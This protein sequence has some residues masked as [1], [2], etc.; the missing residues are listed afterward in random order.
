MPVMTEHRL[1]ADLP[2]EAVDAFLAVAGPQSGSTLMMAEIRHLG[3][4]LREI[5]P[6]HG[7]LAT[8]DAAY[9]FFGGG[10]AAT[11]EMVAGLQAALPV[12]KA[13]MA[14]WDAGRGYLNFEET[15]GSHTFYDEVTHRHLRRIKTQVDPGDI[16]MSNHP[17]AP[18]E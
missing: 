12:Y 10:V 18:A 2:A 9:L 3:G 17:I 6:G 13:A 15:A 4:A 1:L 14:E 16:F 5:R 8:L 11:P 7:A